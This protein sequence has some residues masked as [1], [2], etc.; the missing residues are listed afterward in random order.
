MG[1]S[2][3]HEKSILAALAAVVLLTGSLAAAREY[4]FRDAEGISCETWTANRA[5][6]N[7]DSIQDMLW[8]LGF[9]S[10]SGAMEVDTGAVGGWLDTY[11][12][13]NPLKTLREAATALA[14]IRL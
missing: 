4:Q 12:R 11:C 10:G 13:A 3:G 6:G 5:T 9:L 1:D 7:S 8:I 2:L 14:H